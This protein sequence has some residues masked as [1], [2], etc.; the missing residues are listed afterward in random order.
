MRAQAMGHN[1]RGGD[2]WL[3]CFG[4]AH[5]NIDV[6]AD[7]GGSLHPAMRGEAGEVAARDTRDLG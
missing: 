5:D 4:R 1:W 3:W 6:A 2:R 7:R